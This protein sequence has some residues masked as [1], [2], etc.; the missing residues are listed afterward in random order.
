VTIDEEDA[1]MPRRPRGP[2]DP[3][4][5]EEPVVRVEHLEVPLD[6][7]QPDLRRRHQLVERGHELG[8]GENWKLRERF[9]LQSAVKRR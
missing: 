2:G 5:A 1:R 7:G 9:A 8:L 4:S 3:V 6:V